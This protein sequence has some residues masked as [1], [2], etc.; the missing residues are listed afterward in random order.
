MWLYQVD[1]EV[2]PV[3][4]GTIVRVS[5]DGGRLLRK[6]TRD[7]DTAIDGTAVWAKEQDASR[8][9]TLVESLLDELVDDDV[10]SIGFSGQMHGIVYVGSRGEL[11][12]PL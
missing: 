11:L 6:S 5:P 8:I 2:F 9:A 12:S 3:S 7:N 4:E 1:G 10:A